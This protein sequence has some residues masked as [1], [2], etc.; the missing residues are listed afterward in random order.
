MSAKPD[1]PFTL[2]RATLAARIA[3]ACALVAACNEITPPTGSLT[4][5]E[6]KGPTGMMVNIRESQLEERISR[7]DYV[8]KL[9]V[10]K[11]AVAGDGIHFARITDALAAARAGRISRGETTNAACRITISVAAGTYIGSVAPQTTSEIEAL[12]L[13]IDVPDITLLGAF[14]M[15]L[16]A[17]GRPTGTAVA[18]TASVTTITASPGLV[19]IKTGNALDKYAE[20]LIVINAHPDG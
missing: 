7:G 16:D 2:R 10:S 19:S 15:P 8:T 9:L 14:Q 20:P 1:H 4:V 11:G 13:T 18:G 5:C 6:M 3:F 17:K 12:P